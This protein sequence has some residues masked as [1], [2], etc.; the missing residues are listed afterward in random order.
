[1]HRSNL[2]VTINRSN[3][4]TIRPNCEHNHISFVPNTTEKT[5]IK[6][7]TST[8]PDKSKRRNTS[9]LCFSPHFSI[10]HFTDWVESRR[11]ITM[12]WLMWKNWIQNSKSTYTKIN[13]PFIIAINS[14]NEKNIN[15][16]IK[17]KKWES[18]LRKKINQH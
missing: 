14:R 12:E 7:N 10:N 2:V 3:L 9:Y 1:M 15:E 6:I 11:R 13:Y 8:D 17:R 4:V 5:L 16:N 18:Y